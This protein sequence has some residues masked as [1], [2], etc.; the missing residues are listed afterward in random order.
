MPPTGRNLNHIKT[1]LSHRSAILRRSQ[2][3]ED[4]CTKPTAEAHLYDDDVKMVREHK[5]KLK[6]LTAAEKD[7]A[8]QKYQTGLSMAAVAKL[9]GCHYTTI[10]RLLRAKGVVVRERGQN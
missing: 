10:G 6:L 1:A 8:I 7:E 9:Y 3:A 4:A 2:E 5:L